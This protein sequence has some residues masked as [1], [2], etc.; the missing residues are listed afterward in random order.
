M[1]AKR[2]VFV[3]YSREDARWLNKVKTFLRPLERDAELQLW[4]DA[5]I[6]PS[7]NW[8]AE[9]QTAITDADAAILLISQNFLASDYVASDELP[10]MLTAAS[11]RGLKIFPIIVSASF[12][13]GSP[14]LKFQA[15]NSTSA[16]L[17]SVN[18]SEQNRILARLAESID[19]L[20]KVAQAGVTNEW[21]ERFRTR[22]IAVD[23]GR[24]NLGDNE[25]YHKLH[26]LPE[27]EAEVRSFRFGKYVVT[28]S[29]WAA[30][31]NTQPWVNQK[32]VRYGSEVP[33][34]YVTWHDVNDFIRKIN[35]A[36][37]GFIYR[38]PAEAEWEYAA[39][40]GQRAGKALAKFCFGNDA[41][42]LMRYGWFDQNASLRGNNYAHPVGELSP[43]QLGLYDMH[44]NVWEWTGDDVDGLRALRGGGF[45][46]MA[47]GASSAFRVVQKPEVTGEAVGF[48]LVQEQRY[49][50]D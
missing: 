1:T 17:D 30:V 2:T 44:G 47:E 37:S 50:R 12:L 35:K 8:H 3:S 41:S 49:E 48:R 14:L 10:Q 43:N 36:D 22:F 29:E 20:L 25:L 39:R 4:S 26:A 15:V 11:E 42:Q 28:Q 9:I 6:R 23:G 18:E 32:N 40:G 46:F 38:L 45:N 13:R 5:D 31:M 21:L 33:A 34:V 24:S 16:P 19:D 7:S 27:R